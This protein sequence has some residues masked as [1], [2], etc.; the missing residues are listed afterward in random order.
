MDCIDV[1][2]VSTFGGNPLAMAGLVANLNY[3]IDND[4][5]SNSLSM[6]NRLRAGISEAVS[7]A[8]WIAELRGKGL[9]LAIETVQPG[10]IQPNVAAA[11][12]LMEK[13]KAA[14]LLL[15]KGGLYGN[16]LRIAPPLT[17]TV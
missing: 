1:N 16:V 11:G 6:G 10:S 15:G 2:S 9:M 8:D 17:I 7:E 14:G 3:L 5:Q 13:T 4:L 12:Q